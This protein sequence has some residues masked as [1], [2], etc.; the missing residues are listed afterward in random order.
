MAQIVDLN[1]TCEED[2]MKVQMTFDAPFNGI[3]FPK[4]YFKDVACRYVTTGADL[5][6]VFFTVF[7]DE[8]GS[9]WDNDVERRIL[10]TTLVIQ[11]DPHVQE[12]WDSVRRLR[13]RWPLRIQRQLHFKP[14]KMSPLEVQ[15]STFDAD[16]VTCWM[17]VRLDAGVPP[18][19]PITIGETLSLVIHAS[20]MDNSL[21]VHVNECYASPTSDGLLDNTSSIQLS[22]ERG[23]PLRPKLMGAFYKSRQIATSERNA[24]VLAFALINAFAFPDEEFVYFTCH[25][26]ICRESCSG[27]VCTQ[28]IVGDPNYHLPLPPP[29]L[30]GPPPHRR[31]IGPRLKR[32]VASG[33]IRMQK[34]VRIERSHS[35]LPTSL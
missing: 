15:N 20:D 6:Y 13:C 10:E 35:V 33:V 12:S 16:D 11:G 19:D 21:D 24:S 14:L 29:P 5:E 17:D 18:T 1:V 3:I 26:T 27:D 7:P 30:V 23:C 22:D 25:V 28:E 32:D 8:C 2:S 4:G 34:S 9:T 31:I